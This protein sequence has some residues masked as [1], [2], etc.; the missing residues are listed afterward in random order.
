MAKGKSDTAGLFL[1]DTEVGTVQKAVEILAARAV[2]GK[3]AKSIDAAIT[4][5]YGET[6][7]YF[8]SRLEQQ[9]A[10]LTLAVSGGSSPAKALSKARD[11]ENGC[12]AACTISCVNGCKNSCSGSCTGSCKGGCTGVF[13]MD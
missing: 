8:R 11:C 13:K 2:K 4:E 9:L 7:P 6:K 3:G 10:L 12:E 1:T 5:L